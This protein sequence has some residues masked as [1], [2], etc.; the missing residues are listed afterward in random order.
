MP[1]LR[2]GG[3]FL[4]LPDTVRMAKAADAREPATGVAMVIL[5][6]VH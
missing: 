3:C 4:A 2:R 6:F 1:G 5:F